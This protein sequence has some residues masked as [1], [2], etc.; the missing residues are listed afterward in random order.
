M[1]KFQALISKNKPGLTGI[2]VDSNR[3][4]AAHIISDSSAENPRPKLVDFRITTID[5]QRNIGQ[6]LEKMS[7]D[8]KLKH[9]RCTSII[10]DSEYNLLQIG[11]PNVP[12]DELSTA[13]RWQI[14]DLVEF[15]IEEATVDTFPAPL[16]ADIS[17]Q[18]TLYVI[19]AR[20][21]AIQRQVDSLTQAGINLE[22]IDIQEMA[23]RNIA[24]TIAVDNQTTAIIW[25]REQS[26]LLILV[27]DNMIFL[28]RT[29]SSGIQ[30]LVNSPDPEGTIENLALEIQR[31][32]DYYD[33]RYKSHPLRKLYLSPGVHHYYDSLDNKLSNLLNLDVEEIDLADHLDHPDTMPDNWQ[34]NLFIPIA[35]ALRSM[36][37]VA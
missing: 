24:T 13:I 18:Q 3:L 34:E 30:A 19:T 10:S 31:S 17:A 4:S 1:G 27:K 21:E 12:E 6:L 7:N 33:S 5:G 22:I 28:N 9:S 16:E 11:K 20:N 8:M 25:L 26:G 15:P 2:H 32:L 36:D 23:L 29:L 35:A 14:K 37:D